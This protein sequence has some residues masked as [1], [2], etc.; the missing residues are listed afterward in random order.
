ME[1]K[2]RIEWIDLAK[3]LCMFF[4]ILGH[5]PQI[6]EYFDAREAINVIA[7]FRMPLYFLL[8]GLFFKTYSSFRI[9]CFKKI[10]HLIIPYLFFYILNRIFP[11][12]Q[13]YQNWFL[14][15]LFCI[16]MIGYGLFFVG[17][18]A[19]S[20]RLKDA[21]IGRPWLFGII[22][23]LFSI[24]SGTIGN[25]CH[26]ENL[27]YPLPIINV[28]AVFIGSSLVALP[29]FFLGY[30]LRNYTDLLRS[31]TG[32]NLKSTLFSIAGLMVAV[33]VGYF[34]GWN[35]IY[36]HNN[37]YDIP[38]PC[39]YIAGVP[40]VIAVLL[41]AR[42]L[43]RIPILS[44]IG[45]YSIIVLITHLQIYEWMLKLVEMYL[46]EPDNGYLWIALFLLL[47][48]IEVPVIAFCK[49]YLPYIFAQKELLK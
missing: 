3:G 8:S 30:Y 24:I 18:H 49:R 29:F 40:S 21:V 44:Y 13:F 38:I 39:V 15:C 33:I 48:L 2:A 10:N 20:Q 35:D 7:Y 36:F 46:P 9:F 12:L 27:H 42:Q 6:Y 37:T 45:R 28:H 23:A 16:N 4:V 34:C 41:I 43:V 5:V 19:I 32:Y 17:K 47:I 1:E 11:S 25:A 14:F 31:T 22:F 26:L